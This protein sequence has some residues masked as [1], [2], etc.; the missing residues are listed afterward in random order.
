M[1]AGTGAVRQGLGCVQGLQ[2]QPAGLQAFEV[3]GAQRVQL[4]RPP[5]PVHAG[6]QLVRNARTAADGQI[7]RPVTLAVRLGLI[8]AWPSACTACP[9]PTATGLSDWACVQLVSG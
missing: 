3:L 5:R 8:S 7:L 4:H 1:P 9:P 2:A 6:E